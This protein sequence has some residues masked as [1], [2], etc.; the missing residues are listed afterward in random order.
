MVDAAAGA[1]ETL[2]LFLG[3]AGVDPPQ[4]PR[5]WLAAYYG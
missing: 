5:W 3:L 2:E 4:E 1:R